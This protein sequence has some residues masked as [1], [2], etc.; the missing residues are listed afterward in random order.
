M[1]VGLGP[2]HIVLDGDPALRKWGTTPSNFW[3]MSV[4]AKRMEGSRCHLVRRQD[5]ALATL[6]KMR[7]QLPFERGSALFPT[8]LPMSVCKTAGWIRAQLSTEVGLASAQVTLCQIGTQ[9]PAQ[10]GAQPLLL[11]HICCGQTVAHLSN[12]K[13]IPVCVV[14]VHK[15]HQRHCIMRSINFLLTLL[16]C[17]L[18]LVSLT[19]H[20]WY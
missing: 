19:D 8:F 14:L 6:C 9:L 2:C 10:K 15:A 7:T 1:E 18:T 11:A 12:C 16:T 3:P 13:D 4:V 20:G 5:S 17:L